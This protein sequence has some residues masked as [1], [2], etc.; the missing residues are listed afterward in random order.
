MGETEG[1]K[2]REVERLIGIIV[3][4]LGR[5]ERAC[6]VPDNSPQDEPEVL[7]NIVRISSVSYCG[8]VAAKDA[9]APMR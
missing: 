9:C 8:D 7:E 3:C 6:G 5:D 2:E 4:E 1:L